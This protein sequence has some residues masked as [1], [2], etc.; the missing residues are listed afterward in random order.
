LSVLF[1]IVEQSPIRKLPVNK[2]VRVIKIPCPAC[3]K[4]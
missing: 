3:G 2:Y 4:L 1:V